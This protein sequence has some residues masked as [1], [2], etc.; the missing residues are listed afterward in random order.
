MEITL[1]PVQSFSS[2][3]IR[4]RQEDARFPDADS[5]ASTYSAFCVCDGVGGSQEGNLASDT[6]CKSIGH[7]MQRFRTTDIFTITDFNQVLDSAYDSLD[8]AAVHGHQDMATTLTFISFNANGVTMAHIGDSRIYHL[9]QTEGVLYRTEDHSLVNQM[10]RNGMITPEEAE[11]S[12]Q[13]NV[14]TRCMEPV[15]VDELRSMA[16]FIQTDDVLPGDVFFLCT[17]GVYGYM[18]EDEMISILLAQSLSAEEKMTRLQKLCQASQDNYTATLITV[19]AVEGADVDGGSQT[20]SAADDESLPP[21]TARRYGQNCVASEVESSQHSHVSFWQRLKNKFTTLT[22]LAVLLSIP[23]GLHAQK[24]KVSAS[25]SAPKDSVNIVTQLAHQGDVAAQLKL[26]SWY[27]EGSH[28]LEPDTAKA[29][30]YWALASKQENA[31]AIEKMA[32]CYRYGWAAEVDSTTAVRLYQAAFKKGNTEAVARQDKLAREKGNLFSAMLLNECYRKAVGVKGDADLANEY[33][34]IAA[35]NG[36]PEHLFPVA[37]YYLNH[38]KAATSYEWFLLAAERG[39]AGALYYCGYLNF[40][41]QGILQDK[42]KAIDFYKRSAEKDF[43]MAQYQL[44]RALLEGDGVEVDPTTAVEWLKKAAVLGNS[45]AQ[46]LLGT[47]YIDGRG[48]N[49]DFYLATMW[50]SASHASHKGELKALLADEKYATYAKYLRGWKAMDTKRYDDAKKLSRE[51]KKAGNPEGLTMRAMCRAAEAE[52]AF[53]KWWAFQT[54][55]RAA[56]KSGA[57]KYELSQMYL[58][59]LG[60][61]RNVDKSLRYIDEAAACDIPDALSVVANQHMA[62]V[63]RSRDLYVAATI[64]LRLEAMHRLSPESAIFLAECYRQKVAVLPDL[65]KAEERIEKLMNHVK[66]DDVAEMLKNVN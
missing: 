29:L 62:D 48:V 31:Y 26:A 32:D 2:K 10:V 23:L 53:G 33:L 52:K 35:K 40:E 59:G 14:I 22:I 7:S 11:D 58:K 38:Y 39:H 43:P 3:G 49:A 57:A 37:L 47:C 60:T 6:V 34:G 17:D 50:L 25:D 55:K 66:T 9:R 16:T 5:P 44:G 15:N 18:D 65:D 64:Y 61:K 41:G 42:A 19:S 63:F 12:Q 8:H 46:W 24:V 45:G 13:K 1:N 20:S 36:L 51:V 30:Q 4:P 27:F 56:R 21:H 28:S 54:M